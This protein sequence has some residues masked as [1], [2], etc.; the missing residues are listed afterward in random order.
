MRIAFLSASGRMGGAERCLYD[1]LASLRAAEPGLELA[2]FVAEEG[3]LASSAAALGVRVKVLPFPKTLARLGDAGAGGPAGRTVGRA[4]LVLKLL[5]AAPAAALYVRRLRRALREFGADVVHANG[6]KMHVLGVRARP[7][8]RTPVVWHVHDYVGRRPLMARLLKRY[9]H[10]CAAALVNSESVGRDLHAV[11]GDSLRIRRLYNAVDLKT[12]AP[13]G[14]RL[15]LDGLA[16]LPPA[17]P[18]TVRVGLLATL[19]R[20]KGHET[21]LRSLSMLPRGAAVRGYVIGGPVYQ[22]EGSQFALSELRALAARLGVEDR[23]GFTG[24]VEDAAGAMRALDVVVHASTEPEPFGLVIAEGMACGRAVVASDSGGASEILRD[25]EDAL[26]HPPGDTERLARN[27]ELLARDPDLRVRLGRAGAETARR[28]FD[29][30]RLAA[31]LLPV[32]REV[33]RHVDSL[34]G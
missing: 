12:F 15:D 6:L 16:G 5:L 26:T 1:A 21:F 2:L 17:A 8:A 33:I 9:A 14:G 3:A 20:W 24:F 30:G 23:V 18:G 32:Y 10:A 4:A 34:S 27:I 11:C 29:R 7:S 22:T 13:E 28:R 19:A 31:E 25:G